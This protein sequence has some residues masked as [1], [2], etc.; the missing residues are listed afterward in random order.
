MLFFDK[1][2]VSL[3]LKSGTSRYISQPSMLTV[4]QTC[5]YSSKKK[6]LSFKFMKGRYIVGSL[7]I[8]DNVSNAHSSGSLMDLV[9]LTAISYDA[10]TVIFN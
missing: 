1:K 5:H 4:L 9:K 8:L 3:P 7:A 10:L 6:K 2:R